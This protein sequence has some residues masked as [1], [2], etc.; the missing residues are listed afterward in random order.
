MSVDSHFG[1]EL[2]KLS[3]SSSKYKRYR[4]QKGWFIVLM[5]VDKFHYQIGN[6]EVEKKMKEKSDNMEQGNGP[7][8][9]T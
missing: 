4:Y 6:A 1:S 3:M 2:H 5:V 7:S 8:I 9:E